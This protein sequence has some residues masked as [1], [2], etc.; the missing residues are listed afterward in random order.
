MIHYKAAYLKEFMPDAAPPAPTTRVFDTVSAV[1]PE[2]SAHEAHS[3]APTAATSASAAPSP[4]AA[5]LDP[6]IIRPS[7]LRLRPYVPGKPIEEVKRE[8]GLP[9]DFPIEKL[10]SNE[11]VLGPSPRA[12]EAMQSALQDVW[13]YPDD[14]CFALK[15]ALAAHWSVSSEHLLIGNGSDEILH[16]LG[17]ALLDRE[18][19]DEAIIG[20]P[21]FVQY[22]SA[23]MLADCPFHLVPLTPDM[24][25]DLPAM[26]ERVNERTRLLFI[27]NPNNP[28]GTVVTRREFEALL[29]DLPPHVVVVL[30]QAYY[31]YVESDESPEG[32]NSVRDGHNVI[33]LHTFSKAYALAGLR[34]GYCI[35]RPELTSYL[36]QVR[37]PFNVNTL[38]QAAAIA[39]LSDP[40]QIERARAMNA[41]GK[42]QLEAALAAMQLRWVPSEANFLLVDCGRE[43]RFVAAQL[44]KRGV[45]VRVGFGLET[46]LRVTVGTQ[47]MNE[48]FITSLRE[49]LQAAA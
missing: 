16:F 2:A 34:V 33:V 18:R 43:A 24:R 49:I 23:A 17:L 36:S 44:M 45:I 6:A 26:R 25:H 27:A 46:W 19:G 31:E 11:N 40:A 4:D 7:V 35:A 3:V 22:K 9:P 21:S 37:G 10:A 8:L 1:A 28:T 42:R 14:D 13:L 47:A 38:A 12:V 41:A 30:D 15:N 32:L 48:R 39:S 29:R 20:D 5:P